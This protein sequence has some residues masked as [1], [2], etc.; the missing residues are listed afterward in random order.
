MASRPVENKDGNMFHKSCVRTSPQICMRRAYLFRGGPVCPE[1][2]LSTFRMLELLSAW[3]DGMKSDPLHHSGRCPLLI[4]S[5][6]YGES[7][8]CLRMAWADTHNPVYK[9]EISEIKEICPEAGLHSHNL[10]YRQ[11]MHPKGGPL[12][13]PAPVSI[14]GFN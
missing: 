5:N 4:T 8:P 14:K 13:C 6:A 1:A 11:I 12:A 7:G 9:I 10:I 3:P 2:G